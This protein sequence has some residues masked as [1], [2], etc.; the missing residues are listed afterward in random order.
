MKIA[1]IDV[2]KNLNILNDLVSTNTTLSS[3]EKESIMETTE[4]VKILM[5]REYR[6]RFGKKSSEKSG[7]KRPPSPKVEKEGRR[8]ERDQLPSKRYPNVPVVTKELDFEEAPTCPCCNEKMRDTK[9]KEIIE[10]LTVIPKQYQIYRFLKSKYSCGKCYSGIRTAPSPP[11]IVPGS[12]YGDDLVLDAALSKYCDLIPMERYVAMAARNGVVG[13]PPQ[14]LIGLT[15]H[16]SNFLEI[17]HE[18]LKRE[19]QR[20]LV[21]HA[22]ETTHRMLERGG[23]K[24][25]YLWGFSTTTSCFFE[26]KNT[27]AGLVAEEFLHVCVTVYLVSDVYSGYA[28]AVSEVNKHREKENLPKLF[29][30]NCNAHARRKFKDAENNFEKEVWLPLACYRRI[31]KLEKSVKAKLEENEKLEYRRKM[32]KYF[33]VIQRHSQRTL[34]T[35]SPRS[36]L[37]MAY[38]YFLKNFEGLTYCLENVHI[39]PDNNSQESLLRKP[40]VG[41]KTW[42]GTHSKRGAGTN[43]VLFSIVGACHLNGVNPREY[44]PYVVK[45]IHKGKSP[46]TPFEYRNMRAPPP[47]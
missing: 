42:Y 18:K 5:E 46:P 40:V 37:A 28:K 39:P 10:Y 36:S 16:L 11:R 32:K 12:S 24:Q 43:A 17:I 13:L 3:L 15:H 38:K 33:L 4:V 47:E 8:G 41:R 29:N 31:Y 30:A 20:S 7:D 44:F 6:R 26:I 35:C 2:D 45:C 14:S 22:D 19:V 34:K 1:K 25:W 27:R 23:G 9:L 21:V